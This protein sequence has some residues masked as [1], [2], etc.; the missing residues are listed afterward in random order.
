MT[1]R[2]FK[3]MGAWFKSNGIDPRSEAGFSMLTASMAVVVGMLLSAGAYEAVNGDVSQQ[4]TSKWHK[5]AY[6]SAQT[7]A[8]DYIGHMAQDQNYFTYCDNPNLLGSSGTGAGAIAINDTDTGQTA[9]HP[10]RRWLQYG[11]AGSAADNALTSQY[12]IDLIPANGASSCK[13]GSDPTAAMVDQDSGTVRVRVTGRAGSPVPGAGTSTMP[14]PNGGATT[15]PRTAANIDLWRQKKWKHRSIVVEF[16]QNGFLDYAYFTDRESMDPGLYTTNAAV[17]TACSSYFQSSQGLSAA[18][19]GR[20]DKLVNPSVDC[21]QAELTF[22]NS[23]VINGPFHTNDSILVAGWGT[24]GPTFGRTGKADA[25]EIHDQGI[26]AYAAAS[27]T[28]QS[29]CPYRISSNG[30]NGVSDTSGAYTCPTAAQTLDV[31]GGPVKL[32]SEAPL[33][34]LPEDNADLASWGLPVNGG[35]TYSGSTKIVLKLGGLMDVYQ[36][37]TSASV[38]S[39]NVPYP[40]SGVVYVETPSG[41]AN[42]DSRPRALTSSPSSPFHTYPFMGSTCGYV[43]VSGTYDKSLTIASDSDVI[44]TS[45]AGAFTAS[46]GNSRRGIIRKAS[47]TSA[48]LGLVANKYIRIRNYTV[49]SVS[50][51]AVSWVDAAVLALKHSFTVDRFDEGSG[52]GTLNVNGGIAQA[53]RGPVAT[54]SGSTGYIKNYVYDGRLKYLTPP[55]FLTPEQ[56]NWKTS[57]MREQVPACSCTFGGA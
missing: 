55:H 35:I 51:N 52:L 6:A 48:V 33:L 2:L 22:G 40:T 19:D 24:S 37:A 4:A 11:A 14:N 23:D 34:Q 39:A 54:G 26:D 31:N 50:G 32:G 9:S 25:V 16:R 45:S 15:V 43:E 46:D 29:S 17:S 21:G 12:T 7:G 3:R 53:F 13:S 27:G 30:N 56:S 8:T 49:D 57:R 38:T 47:A 36:P 18:A 1:E 20:R 28:T 5:V 10:N 42:C 41:A 44:V